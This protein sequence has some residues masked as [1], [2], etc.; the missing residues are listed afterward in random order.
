MIIINS[1]QRF[2]L[3]VNLDLAPK[4]CQLIILFSLVKEYLMDFS[5]LCKVEQLQFQVTILLNSFGNIM[6]TMFTL[7]KIISIFLLISSQLF[8]EHLVAVKQLSHNPYLSTVIAMLSS[9][10]VAEKEATKWLKYS[11]I[12]QSLLL[13]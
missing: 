3:Y 11:E 13:T 10:L 8:Q 6:F 9:M 7:F 5:L 2:G 1:L 12:F 4:N